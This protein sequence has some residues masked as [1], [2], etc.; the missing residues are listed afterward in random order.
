MCKAARANWNVQAGHRWLPAAP[1]PAQS[2]LPGS[3]GRAAGSAAA[4]HTRS[5]AALPGPLQP[6]GDARQGCVSPGSLRPGNYFR[7]LNLGSAAPGGS[8]Q[9]RHGNPVSNRGCCPP[10][11]APT[12]SGCQAGAGE[13]HLCFIPAAWRF[14]AMLRG[15][16]ASPVHPGHPAHPKA[17]CA[18][19]CTPYILDHP[20]ARCHSP[21]DP[22]VSLPGS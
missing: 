21:R 11:A 2:C 4:L 1:A 7:C 10:H 18:P 20:A 22:H 14:I 6:G 9:A 13:E 12:Q 3:A 19:P 8:S 5:P 15:Q 16:G 17:P